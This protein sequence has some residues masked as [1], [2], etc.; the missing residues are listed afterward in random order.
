MR[1]RTRRQNV[2]QLLAFSR[3]QMLRPELISAY[4]ALSAMHELLGQA[5]GEAVCIHLLADDD[6]WNCRVTQGN[7]I[8]QS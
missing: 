8:R 3:N 7:W 6:L 5:A 1:R 4:N 2:G